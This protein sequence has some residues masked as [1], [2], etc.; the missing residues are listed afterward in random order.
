[1]KE[2]YYSGLPIQKE[3]IAK[4]EWMAQKEEEDQDNALNYF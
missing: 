2:S 3:L 1:M 4:K